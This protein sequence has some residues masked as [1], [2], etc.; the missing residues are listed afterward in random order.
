MSRKRGRWITCRTK[1]A[2]GSEC[3]ELLRLGRNGKKVTCPK[4]GAVYHR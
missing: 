4:D 1:K 2:D 3:G